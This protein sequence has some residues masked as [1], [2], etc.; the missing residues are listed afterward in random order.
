MSIFEIASRSAFKYPTIRGPVNTDALW[1]MPLKAP[2]GFDL[3]SVA[4][5]LYKVLKDKEEYDFVEN[6]VPRGA[7]HDAVKLDIVKHI[8]A[9]KLRDQ[10]RREQISLGKQKGQ[11]IRQIIEHKEN[12]ALS[13]LSIDELKKLAGDLENGVDID[14]SIIGSSDTSSD[15]SPA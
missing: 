1:Q 14:S 4:K 11:A 3:N 10:R 12:E 7:E 8:I 6:S 5:E 13:G 2:D 15:A 9:M